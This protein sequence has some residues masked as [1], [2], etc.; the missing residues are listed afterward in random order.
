MIFGGMTHTGFNPVFID[1][2][3]FTQ[4][5]AHYLDKSIMAKP[6]KESQKPRTKKGKLFGK[7]KN[8]TANIMT[9]HKAFGV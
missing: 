4:V 5:K 9:V 8:A 6:T 7:L 1:F 2:V 3:D